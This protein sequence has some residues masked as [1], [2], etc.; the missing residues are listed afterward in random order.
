M[1]VFGIFHI[2]FG[3]NL[4]CINFARNIHSW[5]I[6]FHITFCSCFNSACE[7]YLKKDVEILL[8]ASKAD[9]WWKVS[10]HQTQTQIS[11]IKQN[12]RWRNLSHILQQ[13][14]QPKNLHTA[15]KQT[16]S[17][18][19]IND[20]HRYHSL[21]SLQASC[22]SVSHVRL[23]H[24]SHSNVLQPTFLNPRFLFT[25]FLIPSHRSTYSFCKFYHFKYP[26]MFSFLLW[27]DGRGKKTTEILCRCKSFSFT[28][29]S[30]FPLCWLRMGFPCP[31]ENGI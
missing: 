16:S 1:F 27:M 2:L 5:P 26:R 30:F 11:F 25:N 23:Q 29:S 22:S 24:T 13:T 8:M 19:Y 17:A 21:N 15:S 31:S 12:W 9:T 3:G 4:W 20:E 6:V 28:S 10:S 14:R 18:V 7:M